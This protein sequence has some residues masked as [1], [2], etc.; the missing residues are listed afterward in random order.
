M[1]GATSA[2]YKV[3]Q[4]AL[5]GALFDE[6]VDSVDLVVEHSHV[7]SGVPFCI[8][9]VHEK[10]INLRIIILITLFASLFVRLLFRYLDLLRKIAIFV[11]VLYYLTAFWY[12]RKIRT[13]R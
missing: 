5:R 6:P 4:R 10:I 3:W 12:G 2:M 13:E 7:Q 8:L 11:S 1:P 9:R